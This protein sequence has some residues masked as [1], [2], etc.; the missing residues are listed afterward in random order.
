MLFCCCKHKRKGR[1]KLFLD[2]RRSL[3]FNLDAEDRWPPNTGAINWTELEIFSLKSDLVKQ[4]TAQDSFTVASPQWYCS[5][6]SQFFWFSLKGL[7]YLAKLRGFPNVHFYTLSL[8]YV[9]RSV[10]PFF[11]PICRMPYH[12]TLSPVKYKSYVIDMPVDY[13]LVTS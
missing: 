9:R 7:Y 3:Q 4:V 8:Y 11:P 5:F 2:D 6:I 1:A 12:E 13:L 10:T